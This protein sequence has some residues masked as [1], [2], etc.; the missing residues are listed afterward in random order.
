M[1]WN[2]CATAYMQCC[3]KIPVLAFHLSLFLAAEHELAM[4]FIF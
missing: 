4:T 1:M 2:F 3:K